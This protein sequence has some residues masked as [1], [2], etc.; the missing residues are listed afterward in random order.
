MK[1]RSLIVVF[2]FSCRLLFSDKFDEIRAILIEQDEF[3]TKYKEPITF[4]QRV[5][6][7]IPGGD[8]WLAEWDNKRCV[9]YSIDGDKIILKNYLFDN[10]NPNEIKDMNKTIDCDIMSGIPGKRIGMGSSVIG[11]YNNDGLDE[12][13]YYGFVPYFYLGISGYDSGINDLVRYCNIPFWIIDFENGP[14]PVE[15]MNYQGIDGFR[16]CYP[17]IATTVHPPKHDAGGLSW[18]FYAW[19]EGSR[20]FVELAEIGEDIDYSMFTKAEED[21]P[22]ESVQELPVLEEQPPEPE[23]P[24]SREPAQA[25][26]IMKFICLIIIPLMVVSC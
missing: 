24:A 7:G 5:N 6:M 11:D 16:V 23:T 14:T 26:L 1:K 12:I 8:N 19:D 3:Y 4:L 21:V 20:R 18:Y 10:K 17:I 25:G 22:D 15:F 9:I 13:F 2:L